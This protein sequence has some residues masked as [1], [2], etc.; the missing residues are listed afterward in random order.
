MKQPFAKLSRGNNA[1]EVD[2]DCIRVIVAENLPEIRARCRP[3]SG[4]RLAEPDAVSLPHA[5][6]NNVIPLLLP[7]EAVAGSGTPT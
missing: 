5:F 2:D 1:V 4:S 7:G 3:R 6:Q